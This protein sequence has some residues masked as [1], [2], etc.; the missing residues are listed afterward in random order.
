MVKRG[1]LSSNLFT[2]VANLG[3]N[4]VIGV[5]L[6]PYLV[7]RLG[8]AA[9]GIIPLATTVTSYLGVIT[10]V[11]NAAVARFLTIDIEREDYEKANRTFNTSL[12]GN[13]I[14]ATALLLPMTWLVL[15][16][17]DSI[18]HLP[19]GFEAQAKMF[20]VCTLVVFTLALLT[21][22]F[23]V[24]TYCQ[25]RFDIRNAISMTG[26]ILRIGLIVLLF[27]VFQPQMWHV[28]VSAVIAGVFA[29]LF[30]MKTW[31]TLIPKLYIHRSMLDLSALRELT[32][33][34]KWI[35]ISQIGTILLVSIDLVVV[36]RLFGAEATG[37]YA[38][39]L[40]WPVLLRYLGLTLSTVLGP[41]VL[42]FYANSDIDGLISYTRRA[43]K[44]L[45]LAMALPVG[46]VCGLSK[47]LLIL[48]LGQEF[49]ALSPLLVVM[50][51]H[52]CINLGYLPLHNISM[53][54]NKVRWPGITQLLAGAS[55]LLL[56]LF[57]SKSLGLGLYGV[58]A[59]GAIVLTARNVFFT[60]LYSAHIL[61]K[62]YTIFL[63][64]VLPIGVIGFL[65]AVGCW[66]A[67]FHVALVS[68]PR[69]SIFAGLVSSLYLGIVW[70]FVL[71]AEER[72]MIR[73]VVWVRKN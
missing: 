7:H 36:N 52:L 34:G 58:A 23:E 2:N 57:L 63:K 54:T 38:P 65:V 70:G 13:I 30:S 14:L 62:D 35:A 51:S 31:K 69:M 26:S 5:W 3:L 61:G 43:V 60:P 44:F 55:N 20:F 29:L 47:P 22:P 16:H 49:S 48:W 8:V 59:A 12:F 15:F 21:A 46:L 73:E 33:A 45:G 19:S 53:A 64:E 39:L 9:Y 11:L 42:Y 18:F 72:K 24:A 71:S 68:W 32:A 1:K 17:V 27:N 50:T 67:S 28:G 40:Q 41:T 10:L 66:F 6:T 37:R 4:A 25:N 56:A